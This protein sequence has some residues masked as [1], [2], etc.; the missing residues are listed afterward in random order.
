MIATAAALATQ[1]L[2]VAGIDLFSDPRGSYPGDAATPNAYTVA[3]DREVEAR[4][5][6][7]TMAAFHGEVIVVG[8]VLEARWRHHRLGSAAAPDRV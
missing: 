1:Q 8:D 7:E 6:L 4:F 2:I 5:V 3:H